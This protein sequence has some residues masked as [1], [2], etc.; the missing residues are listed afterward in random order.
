[1]SH[2]RPL[3]D[4]GVVRQEPLKHGKVNASLGM[5]YE[6]DIL[7]K[8]NR[9]PEVSYFPSVER[10]GTRHILHHAWNY[11]RLIDTKGLF[12]RSVYTAGG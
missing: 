5:N 6:E 2:F 10:G 8:K 7:D 3:I 1:M 11:A 12:A 4:G 9:R